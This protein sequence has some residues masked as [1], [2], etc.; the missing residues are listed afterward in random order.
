MGFKSESDDTCASL[1][2]TENRFLDE[3]FRKDSR[4]KITMLLSE[5]YAIPEKLQGSRDIL[6]MDVICERDYQ[7]SRMD[8]GVRV[9]TS[10]LSDTTGNEAIHNVMLEEAILSSDIG[11]AVSNMESRKIFQYRLSQIESMKNDFAFVQGFIRMLPTRDRLLLEEYHR[12][13]GDRHQI[14]ELADS[15]E[16]QMHSLYVRIGR[17]RMKITDMA[18][19]GFDRRYGGNAA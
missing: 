2:L 3:Y 15:Y 8:D 16:L 17:I 9:Q 7:R 10:Y 14:E 12:C 18:L 1:A 19:P 4:G 13:C 6:R 11:K 5:F